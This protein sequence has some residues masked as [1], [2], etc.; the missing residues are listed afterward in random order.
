MSSIVVAQSQNRVIG[1]NNATPWYLPDDLKHFK[2][3]TTGHTVVMGRNTYQSIID[4]LG[5]PL[6]NRRNIIISSSIAD[7]PEGFEVFGSIDEL[8]K[9][10]DLSSND[11]YIIGGGQLYKTILEAGMVDRIFLTQIQ[12]SID[13]D[14]FFPAIDSSQWRE[15][16]RIS[17]KKDE[18]N[19]YDYDFVE[20]RR[21]E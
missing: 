4:H 2:E 10:V 11:V 12:A 6:P 14:I 3:I 19:M 1:K 17:H 15:L 8:S 7:P 5:K 20:L 21:I 9:A 13:G 16:S 18:K